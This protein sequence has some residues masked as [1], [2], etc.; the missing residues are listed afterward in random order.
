MDTPIEITPI[1]L[2]QARILWIIIQTHIRNTD[3]Y[4]DRDLE[5]V[6]I[7]LSNQ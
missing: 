2:L 3:S 7:I 1:D 5:K 6:H 4:S